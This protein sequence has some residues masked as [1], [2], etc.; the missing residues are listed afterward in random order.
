MKR[1]V[2]VIAG[3]VV[4]C[5]G[6]DGTV[7]RPR[8]RSA[9]ETVQASLELDYTAPRDRAPRRQRHADA[10]H[11][12]LDACR[13]HDVDACWRATV[14]ARRSFWHDAETPA[15]VPALVEHCLEG[16]DRSCRVLASSS[17]ILAVL[18]DSDAQKQCERGLIAACVALADDDRATVRRTIATGEA[19][20]ASDEEL[21]VRM[22]WHTKACTLGSPYS[23]RVVAGQRERA[24]SL[25][26][27]ECQ[28]GWAA[29]CALL[30]E[31]ND[32]AFVWQTASR[33]CNEG[34]LTECAWAYRASDAPAAVRIAAL[35]RVCTPLGEGCSALGQLRLAPGPEHDVTAARDA[36]EQGCQI[37][38]DFTCLELAKLYL[39]GTLSEPV[40]HRGKDLATF[41]CALPDT[42]WN[43]VTWDGMPFAHA[44]EHPAAAACALGTVAIERGALTPRSRD[45]NVPR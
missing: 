2:G 43:L 45:A 13:D 32:E 5:H 33:G 9:A 40:A 34:V 16:H 11:A 24:R 30:D 14:M 18:L 41:L 44:V 37:G 21:A 25:A 17:S 20:A 10:V 4:G 22:V 42:K 6:G 8:D 39:D 38:D 27:A 12:L 31:G 15:G 26:T 29:S 19:Q 1:L 23:C 36:F 7:A 28:R 3:L 35:S